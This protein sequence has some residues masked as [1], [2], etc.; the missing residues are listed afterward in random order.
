MWIICDF[1]D[2]LQFAYPLSVNPLSSGLLLKSPLLSG[3]GHLPAVS[4][5]VLLLFWPLSN[6]QQEFNIHHCHNTPCS[7]PPNFCIS[8]VLNFSWDDCKEQEKLKT[9]LMQSF[10]GANKVNYGRLESANTMLGFVFKQCRPDKSLVKKSAVDKSH[11]NR[12]LLSLSCDSGI[13][14]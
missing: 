12:E 11:S 6:S 7:P 3:R 10:L 13:P 4:V 2:V 9:M 1:T 14:S 8:I 5:S